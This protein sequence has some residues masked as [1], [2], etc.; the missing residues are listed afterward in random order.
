MYPPALRHRR[1]RLLW[2]GLLVSVAGTQ[3]QSAAIL[4][5][6]NQLNPDP[7][8]LGAVGAARVLPVIVFSLMAGVAADS[9]NRRRLMFLTQS[10][11]ALLSAFLGLLTW[12]RLDSL[13]V[14]YVIVALLAGIGT[15]DLP[16]R[17]SLVPNLVGREDLTNAF[18]L[19]SIAFQVG[20]IAGPA[21]GG[22][23]LAHL[24]IAY[25]YWINALSYLAVI[26]ALIRMGPVSHERRS[27]DGPGAWRPATL[28]GHVLEGLRFVRSQP[29]ILSTMLLDFFAT[30]FSSATA[31]LPIFAREILKVGAIG[32][33][34]LVAA[35]AIGAGSAALVVATRG[36]IPSQGRTLLTAVTGFGLATIV[37]GLSRSFWLTFGA[38]AM[39]GVTDG[40][41]TIIRNTIRQLRTP[42]HLRGRMTSVNQIFFLGGPQLGELEAGAVAQIWG[43]PISVVTGG[44]GC[45]LA[46]LWVRLR[47][48]QLIRYR[49]TEPMLA[50]AE[51]AGGK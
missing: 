47:Y 18:S 40:V 5:H 32:Y 9:F 15:F 34:W 2:F 26:L 12:L 1:F 13:S 17:Q 27:A 35:P 25:A 44:I 21:L 50:G 51:P 23:V 24:G 16:A 49:G 11:L 28:V 22:I 4:W 37:F 43:A 39:T 48:P 38:L 30:F 6:V 19:T 3:M 45:L 29:L 42:D 10:S 8:A 7:I 46:V 31:L 14:V 36:Q 33:G 20:S 41:S